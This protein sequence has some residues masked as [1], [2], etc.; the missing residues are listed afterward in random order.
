MTI[1]IK[2]NNISL[3]YLITCP[4]I[5]LLD[6]IYESKLN[7]IRLIA[8]VLSTRS[9]VEISPSPF[10]LVNVR[11]GCLQVTIACSFHLHRI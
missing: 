1:N 7:A 4:S 11:F 5:S 9:N 6:M 3:N 10:K 8:P 2:W